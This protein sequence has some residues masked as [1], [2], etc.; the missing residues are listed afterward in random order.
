M[1]LLC[2]KRPALGAT[3]ALVQDL[4]ARRWYNHHQENE[5]T[6]ITAVK[7]PAENRTSSLLNE[8]L[9][10]NTSDETEKKKASSFSPKT[11]AELHFH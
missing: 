3:K 2:G 10:H 11:A 4:K 1:A 8:Y 6:P 9:S 5:G 7:M